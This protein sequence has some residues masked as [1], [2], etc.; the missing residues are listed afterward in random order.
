MGNIVNDVVAY[1]EDQIRVANEVLMHLAGCSLGSDEVIVDHFVPKLEASDHRYF[2]PSR[3]RAQQVLAYL[4][5]ENLVDAV[6]PG[7]GDAQSIRL[8]LTLQGWQRCA[9]IE[10][11]N[12]DIKE[13]LEIAQRRA[14]KWGDK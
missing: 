14:A 1:A 13:Q 3:I 8:T 2:I 9:R 5:S 6:D 7:Y 11:R 10:R 4:R 12:R